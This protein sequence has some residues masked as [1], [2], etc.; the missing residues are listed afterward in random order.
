MRLLIVSDSHG[1]S[2]QIIHAIE[3]E[4]PDACIFLGDGLEDIKVA[5]L[6]Y[7]NLPIYKVAGNCDFAKGVPRE[8]MHTFDG[9][10]IFYTHGHL[11]DVNIDELNLAYKAQEEGALIAL[12]GHTHVDSYNYIDGVHVFN[13]GSITHSRGSKAPSYGVIDLIDGMPSFKIIETK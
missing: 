5:E 9:V 1:K 12:Y 6:T 13:P 8:G 11:Y 3:K 7:P 10:N 4:N 2:G